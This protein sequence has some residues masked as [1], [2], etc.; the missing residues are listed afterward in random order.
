MT[1]ETG[2]SSVHDVL[3]NHTDGSAGSDPSGSSASAPT[4]SAPLRNHR[5]W[6]SRVHREELA[7]LG[8]GRVDQR[9]LTRPLIPRRRVRRQRRPHRI[10]CDPEMPH[11][12]LDRQA[13]G[14]MQPADLRPILQ[15]DY[16][17]RV[18]ERGQNPPTSWGQYSRVVDTGRV[19]RVVQY[20]PGTNDQR[21]RI[22]PTTTAEKVCR[23]G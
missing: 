17:P 22:S 15:T 7:H 11:D 21:A 12:R 23:P 5:R 13:L 8:L 2:G 14:P 9:L 16:P 6:H 18:V 3:R 10:P 1:P 4:R 20:L 19:S